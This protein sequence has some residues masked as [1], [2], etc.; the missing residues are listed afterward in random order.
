MTWGGAR[1][2][3]GRKKGAETENLCCRIK[4]ENKHYLQQRA[5]ET[6]LTVT[7]VLEAIIETFIDEHK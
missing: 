7:E 1:P 5:K 6:G 3:A 4:V 2:G